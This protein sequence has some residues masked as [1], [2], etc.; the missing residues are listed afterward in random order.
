MAYTMP[1]GCLLQFGLRTLCQGL[2]ASIHMIKLH[3]PGLCTPQSQVQL[4]IHISGIS[5]H[6]GG[7]FCSPAIIRIPASC[8]PILLSDTHWWLVWL[9][10]EAKSWARVCSLEARASACSVE[11]QQL[12]SH[13]VYAKLIPLVL[14]CP[15]GHPIFE[16]SY[17]IRGLLR[18]RNKTCDTGFLSL[19]IVSTSQMLSLY[20]S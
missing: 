5:L 19:K 8:V 12:V 13:D 4:F 3:L 10:L 9:C 11:A 16:L 2:S 18:L 6:Y 15:P 1:T 7:S 20:T 17:D 14:I